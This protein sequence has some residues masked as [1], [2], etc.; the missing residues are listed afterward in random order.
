MGI[1]VHIYDVLLINSAFSMKAVM[2]LLSRL[3]DTL[4]RLEISQEGACS[5]T[6]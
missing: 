2:Q 4:R 3:V 5:H 1:D 6:Q